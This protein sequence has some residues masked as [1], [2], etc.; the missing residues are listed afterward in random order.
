MPKH[1]NS[2]RISF[3]AKKL[4]CSRETYL[5]CDDSF[6][7]AAAAAD[8]ARGDVLD[9]GTGSGIQG[10]IAAGKAK[11]VLFADISP[12]ALACARKNAEANRATKKCKCRFV[13]TDLFQSIP[14]TKKFDVILFNPPYLPTK[15]SEKVKGAINSAWD[16]GR[17]GRKV[18]D[19]FLEAFPAHLKTGGA[20]LLLSCH[21]PGTNKT[22]K[23]LKQLGFKTQIA[24]RAR[25]GNERLSVIHAGKG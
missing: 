8:Y 16:G 10:I 22:L 21:L 18:I 14:K 24:G 2:S 1:K 20:L 17:D 19:P 6:L 4:S 25:A 23:K 9:M 3:R 15:P 7:L 11:S 12:Q 5:P 13:E